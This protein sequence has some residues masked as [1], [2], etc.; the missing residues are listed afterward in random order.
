MGRPNE[1]P[2]CFRVRTEE[3]EALAAAAAERGLP[4]SGLI[5]QALRAYGVAMA[6]DDVRRVIRSA[7]PA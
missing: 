2:L 3:R 7:N 5:R 4:V 1:P 6:P